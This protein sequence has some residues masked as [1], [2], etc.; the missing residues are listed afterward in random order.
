MCAAQPVNVPALVKCLLMLGEQP[1]Y[2]DL[3]MSSEYFVANAT[4]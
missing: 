1:Q 4:V 3:L 2:K